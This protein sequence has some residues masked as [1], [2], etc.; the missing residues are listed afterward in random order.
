MGIC[1]KNMSGRTGAWMKFFTFIISLNSDE[2]SFNIVF[3]ITKGIVIFVTCCTCFL[4]VSQ[5][6]N[7]DVP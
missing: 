4:L 1:L 6:K 5:E 2:C 3:T 7:V